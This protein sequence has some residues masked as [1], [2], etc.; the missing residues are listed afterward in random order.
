[1]KRSRHLSCYR[2][3]SFLLFWLRLFLHFSFTIARQFRSSSSFSGET[4]G[5]GEYVL[6]YFSEEHE[7]TATTTKQR[8]KR[9]EEQ[10]PS[11][12]PLR[13]WVCLSLSRCNRCSSAYLL[14]LLLL[15]FVVMRVAFYV[16]FARLRRE[17]F[18]CS[19]YWGAWVFFFLRSLRFEGPRARLPSCYFTPTCV[20]VE[21]STGS[22]SSGVVFIL[23]SSSPH[24][25]LYKEL[26]VVYT[27]D[28]RL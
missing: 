2:F 23:E 24:S 27:H 21:C 8:R 14:P 18:P 6:L 12:M 1:M 26:P 16:R 19:I 28:R 25:M 9:E 10:A 15:L 7:T 4:G 5:M 17:A 3:L 13:H 22:S 11:Y 20:S